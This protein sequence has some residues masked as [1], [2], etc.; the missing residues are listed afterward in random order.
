MPAHPSSFLSAD[1]VELLRHAAVEAER[2]GQLHPS[3]LELIYE[4]KW[5]LLLAPKAYGGL[6]TNLPETLRLL[7]ALSWCDGSVG[8]TTTLCSGAGWFTGF[9][10]PELSKQLLADPRA[11][12]AGSG[13]STGL[14]RSVKQGWEI[15]GHWNH[16]S[17]APH[18]SYFTFNSR[19]ERDGKIL[20]DDK[21]A[22]IL[23]TAW[24]PRKDVKLLNSWNSMGMIATASQSF[25]L[26]HNIVRPDQCFTLDPAY[27]VDTGPLYQ[28]PFL[29]LAETTISA[30]LAGMAQRFLELAEPAAAGQEKKANALAQLQEWRT[31]FY[32]LAEKTWHLLETKQQIPADI[33]SATSYS[34]KR[35]ANGARNL[36]NEVFPYCG[37]MAA[38]R[39]SEINRVWR[40]LNTAGLHS[41]LH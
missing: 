40:N 34:S 30:N 4:K 32:A 16:A 9:L 39:G 22:D 26:E 13:Q 1:S 19:V 36:V 41:L 21:G 17:G 38:N 10:E 18:A 6:G 24:V 35:L 25:E 12:L 29:Q 28:Y 2:L 23:L 8:W 31:A 37:I 15:T 27:A 3:Q 20:Q 5:F 7:E 11:C 14:A 33:L